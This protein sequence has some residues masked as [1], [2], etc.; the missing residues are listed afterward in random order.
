M[1]NEA[2]AKDT[3]GSSL[4]VIYESSFYYCYGPRA[5]SFQF[6]YGRKVGSV[7]DL[8][9]HRAASIVFGASTSTKV[10]ENRVCGGL[11]T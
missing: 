5:N 1:G 2:L 9:V 7:F 8:L 11:S 10:Y 3:K 6:V 4:A